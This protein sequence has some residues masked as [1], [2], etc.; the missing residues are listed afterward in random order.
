[1][2]ITI[3]IDDCSI[4]FNNPKI[5]IPYVPPEDRE[6]ISLWRLFK[7]LGSIYLIMETQPPLLIRI[8]KKDSMSFC[9]I[10]HS[11]LVK[12]F[13]FFGKFIGCL[14]PLC[15]NYYKK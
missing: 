7:L 6:Q 9:S 3:I 15:P 10:C 4:N 11:S 1:M 5:K 12:K 8:V 13:V 2:K 14:Q